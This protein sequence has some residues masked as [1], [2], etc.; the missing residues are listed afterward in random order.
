M[1]RARLKEK[2]ICHYCNKRFGTTIDH[3]VPRAFGGPDAMWN[4]V[5][6]CEPC[7]LKKGS[8]W[9]SCPCDYCVAA[10]T[11]FLSSPERRERTLVRLAQ[12]GD[13]LSDGIVA[14]NRRAK[15]LGTRRRDLRFLYATINSWP[16]DDT[17]LAELVVK[18]E[19]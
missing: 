11:R 13:E 3:I 18:K 17:V 9:P 1:G 10:V 6:S 7:N 19:N 4:Y 8:D 5:P 2:G 12:Q 15:E 14:L 16:K